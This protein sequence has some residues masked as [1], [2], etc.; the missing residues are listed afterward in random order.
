MYAKTN[1]R[2]S[3]RIIYKEKGR[4]MGEGKGKM[5]FFSHSV[6]KSTTSKADYFKHI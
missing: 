3:H 2:N 6:E 5:K 1:T 4:R